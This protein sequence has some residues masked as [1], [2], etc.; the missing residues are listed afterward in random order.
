MPKAARTAI[1]NM[2]KN[3][4]RTSRPS[5]PKTAR[6][7]NVEAALFTKAE[8]Q[9]FLNQLAPSEDV[10]VH[11]ITLEHGDISLAMVGHPSG[12]DMGISKDGAVIP[13]AVEGI[14]S[15]EPCP[16]NCKGGN[17]NIFIVN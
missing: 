10:L 1:D 8:I 15:V 7:P 12:R 17:G 2:R 4:L 5:T 14:Y 16:P 9:T 3:Y 13:T 11:L 6:K